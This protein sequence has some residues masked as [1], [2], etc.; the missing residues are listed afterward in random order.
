MMLQRAGS[1]ASISSFFS[2]S[3]SLVMAD[4]TCDASFCWI[5]GVCVCVCV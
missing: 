3:G 1:L 2:L 4:F 5:Y